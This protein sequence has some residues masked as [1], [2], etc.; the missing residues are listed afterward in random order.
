MRH[1]IQARLGVAGLDNLI[2]EIGKQGDGQDADV[3]IVLDN[4]NSLSFRRRNIP[5]GIAAVARIVLRVA[6]WQIDFNR[7]P[8]ICK[9]PVLCATS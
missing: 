7:R 5:G 2:A 9:A 3:R 8:F 4:Q 6:P 1:G